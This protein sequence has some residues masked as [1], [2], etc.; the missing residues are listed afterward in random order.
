MFS[1]VDTPDDVR[2]Y[3]GISYIKTYLKSKG[4]DCNARVICKE[5]MDEVLRS[6]E[7]FPKLIGI[8][9]YCN[10]LELVKLFCEKIKKQ[11]YKPVNGTF[12]K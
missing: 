11:A 7:D 10:T 9:I 3:M 1:I 2:E 6:Y 8:S 4:L 12:G 5:E